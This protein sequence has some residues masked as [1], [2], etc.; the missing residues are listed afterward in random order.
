[1]SV[2]LSLVAS[3][4]RAGLSGPYTNDFYTL[5]LWHLQDT[6]GTIQ[7]V[8]TNGVYFYDSQSNNP[9]VVPLLISNTPGPTLINGPTPPTNWTTLAGQPGPGI[10]L[11]QSE[12]APTNYGY[13]LSIQNTQY[14]GFF[15]PWYQVGS[16]G[17]WPDLSYAE[18]NNSCSFVNTNTGAFTWEALIQPSINMLT[19]YPSGDQDPEI[20]CTDGGNDTGPNVIPYT[21]RA[22]QFRLKAATPSSG[23]AQIEFNGNISAAGSMIHDFL[24]TI[25]TTGS[26]ALVA[27][28]WY[29][30]AWAFTGT[31]PTNGDPADVMTCYWTLFSPGRTNANVLT[32]FYYAFTYT[33]SGQGTVYTLPYPSNSIIGG[34]PF[35]IGNSDRGVNGGWIGNIA[36]VRISDYYRHPNEFMFNT[37]PADLPPSFGAV[38]TNVLIGYNQTLDISPLVGGTPAPV[39]QWYQNGQPLVGQT[40]A[41]LVIS[42]VTFAADGNYECFGTNS[43][44][45]TNS[46][47]VAVTVGASFDGFFNTGCGPNNNPLDQT[48]PGSVDPHWQLLVDPDPSAVIPDAIVWSDGSPLEPY[49]IVPANGASVWIGSRE[50]TGSGSGTC[51]YQTT[52]QV[53]ETAVSATPTNA[54]LSGSVA[55]SGGTSGNTIQMFLNGV[56]TDIPMNGNPEENFFPFSITNGLQPGSNTLTCTYNGSGTFGNG[57]NLDVISDTGAA[58]TGA[59]V[60]ANQPT[61][62]TNVAGSTVSFQ[63]VALGAPPLDYY[64]LS[65]GVA[66]TQPV[67]VYTTLPYLSFVAT[68]FSASQLTGT[69]YFANYQIVF[70]NSVGSVT[71]QV[72]T[73]DVQ[74]PPLTLVSAGVPIWNAANSE[75][76]IV[77][78]FST[79]V[80]SVTATT[81][82]N[83]SLTGP[84]APGILS[85]VL[86]SA[87]G[88]VVLT[89]NSA[90]NP[91]DVYTLNVQSVNSSLGVTMNPSPASVTIGTYPADVALWVKASQG[92]T[93]DGS[94]GV[95]QWNDLSGNNNNLMGAGA[96]YDPQYVTNSYGYPVVRFVGTNFPSFNYLYAL[97]N[98][99]TG[100]SILSNM[101]VFAV[102][103][104]ATLAGNTN[105]EIIDEDNGNLAN[106]YDYY[107]T[108]SYVDLLR[109]NGSSYGGAQSSKPPTVGVPQLLDV[110][111]QGTSVT[112]RLNG[113]ANGTGTINTGIASAESYVLV[114]ARENDGNFLTGD[115]QELILI[116]QALSSS[117]VA[118]MESYLAGEYNLQIGINPNPTNVVFSITNGLLTLKWPADHTGWQLQAQTNSVS[119]GL[120]TNWANYNP[121]TGPSTQTNQVAIPINLTNGTVFYR[122]IYTP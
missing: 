17:P 91:S 76:N 104:F 120:G 116:G 56:E 15:A 40:N 114:G 85:A 8:A 78:N 55:A 81:A 23:Q 102:V 4:S 86:G 115:L 62:V 65:N 111:M 90:L 84:G 11:E 71:S 87:P 28:D 67:W 7:Y 92:I 21:E 79:G 59:P 49:G 37:S 52:F 18:T 53:D 64:W 1:M 48:A 106:P 10:W 110:V 100:L 45:N 107:A 112:H 70:S 82:V 51:T 54:V 46:V 32:N 113:N 75:T 58:L 63:A 97:D 19:T 16:T 72:A 20:L 88:E 22:V 60:I 14:T 41:T 119:A 103:N 2:I 3:I 5:H 93:P 25:P 69:N 43:F 73:L 118:S 44:G 122:L 68:N 33:N 31:S 101:C 74:L 105:G 6:N 77:V 39:L 24:A 96:P 117:D 121:S 57:L 12:G 108:P 98:G 42:N 99:S 29:H 80:D 9:L 34:G 36:E 50:N 89:L 83:Y 47:V 61:G 27:G 13:A 26:N 66:I 38:P 35:V 94:G 95:S 109:G 30:V